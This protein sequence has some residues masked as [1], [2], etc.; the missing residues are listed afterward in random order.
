MIGG[1]HRIATADTAIDAFFVVVPI[2]IVIGELG[3]LPASY[4]ERLGSELLAPLIWSFHEFSNSHGL[5]MLSLV[6]EQRDGY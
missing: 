1:E 4:G 5:E 2:E 6:I 3:G